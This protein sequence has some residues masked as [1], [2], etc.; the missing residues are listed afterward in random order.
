MSFRVVVR[1]HGCRDD[2]RVFGD[3]QAERDTAYFIQLWTHSCFSGSAGSR[4]NVLSCFA[5]VQFP[6]CLPWQ[7]HLTELD[8]M[9]ESLQFFSV[10]AHSHAAFCSVTRTQNKIPGVLMVIYH[11]LYRIS[12]TLM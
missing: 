6:V 11:L 5:F 7:C 12:S 1:E 9:I 3:R 8:D 10:L 4:S 2:E